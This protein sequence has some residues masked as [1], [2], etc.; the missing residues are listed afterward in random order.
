MRIGKDHRY[1]IPT[2]WGLPAVNGGGCR[3]IVVPHFD[4]SFY[5]IFVKKIHAS[6]GLAFKKALDQ[7]LLQLYRF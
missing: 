5:H 4:V 3:T 6:C 7:I 2:Y 1:G